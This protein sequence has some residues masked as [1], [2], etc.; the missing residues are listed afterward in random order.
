MS[1]IANYGFN[2]FVTENWLPLV[3]VLIDSILAFSKYPITVNCINFDYKFDH[4]RVNTKRANL[5]YASFDA[6]CSVKWSSLLENT[7]DICAMLDAD[8]IATADIDELFETNTKVL[9]SD[10]PLFAKHPHNPFENPVHKDNIKFLSSVFSEH[11]PKMKWVYACGL[12]ALHHKNFIKELLESWQYYARL[13]GSS[14]YIEDEGLLNALLT[15]HQVKQD[16]GY[17]YLPNS[18]LSYD[19]INNSINDSKELY[20]SYLQFDCPVKFY[21]FHGCKDPNIAKTILDQLKLKI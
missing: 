8:M 3:E 1:Q 13:Y 7:Y 21:L 16:I 2:T 19:Y 15:K 6:V 20:E 12:V 11:S 17:N 4:P 14:P 18:T 5:S 10:T 9:S